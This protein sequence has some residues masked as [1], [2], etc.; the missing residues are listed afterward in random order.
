MSI[1]CFQKKICIPSSILSKVW[2][3]LCVSSGEAQSFFSGRI[4]LL[5]RRSVPSLR[6]DQLLPGQDEVL[7][8]FR[9]FVHQVWEISNHVTSLIVSS[10][11]WWLE[12]LQW[13]FWSRNRGFWRTLS[14][15][16]LGWWRLWSFWTCFINLFA[17]FTEGRLDKLVLLAAKGLLGIGKDHLIRL[18][19][20]TMRINAWSH[21]ITQVVPFN[22]GLLWFVEF[23]VAE[24]P[25]CFS[26]EIYYSIEGKLVR[27]FFIIFE[28][29]DVRVISDNVFDFASLRR[30][31]SVVEPFLRRLLRRGINL[32]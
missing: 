24:L 32:L 14:E 8:L 28:A 1:L 23:Q 22:L 16:R 26:H 15:F 18:S 29:S 17:S 6:C 13:S 30:R 20:C 2:I 3:Q 25:V 5:S 21:H 9:V 12:Q 11:H 7:H 10:F 27:M 19:L 31:Q 4:E